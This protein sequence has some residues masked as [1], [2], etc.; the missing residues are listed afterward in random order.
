MSKYFV[1]ISLLCRAVIPVTSLTNIFE[2]F[3]ASVALR[4]AAKRGA[5]SNLNHDNWDQEEDQEE[6]GQFKQAS[7]EQLKGRVIKKA[8]RRGAN[9]TVRQ[10]ESI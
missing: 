3:F 7:Q 9:T 6:A 8:K 4:M 5:T 10:M 1:T 2:P